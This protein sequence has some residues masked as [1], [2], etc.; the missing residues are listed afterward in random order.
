[1]WARGGGLTAG[2]A[3]AAAMVATRATDV[4]LRTARASA[5]AESNQRGVLPVRQASPSE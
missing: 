1:M 4:P 5:T 3:G 2:A